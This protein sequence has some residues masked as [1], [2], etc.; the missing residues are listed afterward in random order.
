MMFIYYQHGHVEGITI[1]ESSL[2]MRQ[3]DA[4]G[5]PLFVLAHYQALLKTIMW[6]PNYVF[7]SLAD[8]THI[9]RPLSEITRV[10][11]HLSSQLTLVG[12]RVKVSKCKFL[13]P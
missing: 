3:G 9:V 2:G 1:I 4:L 12:L 10:F 11:G 6:A 5:G 8:D 7:P 13:S